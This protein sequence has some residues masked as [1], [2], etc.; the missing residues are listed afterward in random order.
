[1]DL[2]AGSVAGDDGSINNLE[3]DQTS[4]YPSVSERAESPQNGESGNAAE[5]EDAV[6]PRRR[7]SS[8]SNDDVSEKSLNQSHGATAHP[9]PTCEVFTFG[10]NS[11]GE[12]AHGDTLDRFV[13]NSVEFV[14]KLKDVTVVQVAAGNEH[15]ALLCSNG[16]VYTCGYND[17]GQ[18]G[19]G[20]TG[21][22]QS[23]RLVQAFQNKNIVK[24]YSANGCEHLIAVTATGSVYT[25]GY[26]SRGQLGHG[27]TVHSSVP[28]LIQSL[29][30]RKVVKVACSYY[31]SIVA[32]DEDELYSF[33]RNDYGQL[34]HGDT[35]DKAKPVRIDSLRGSR[36]LALSCGQYHTVMSI[37]NVGLLACGKNDYGQLGAAQ[38]GD[39]PQN[40]PFPVSSPLDDYSE[41]F[42]VC[43]I[44]CGYYHTIAL[45]NTGAVYSF[46]RNDYG[47][48]GLFNKENK[49]WPHRIESLVHE[50]I[51]QITCGCYHTL[52][53]TNKGVVYAVGRNNHG[54]LGI[55]SPLDTLKPVRI[56]T[57][58]K[59]RIS[60]IAAGFYHSVCLTT[61][62]ED[63]CGGEA[64]TLSADL[65]TLLNNPA[66][67]DITFIVEGRPIY[68]HRCVLMV[69][70]EPLERMLEG[71]M[72][73][74]RESEVE[75]P[76]EEYETFLAFLEFLYTDT[77]KGLLPEFV[78]TNYA[79]NLLCVADRFLVD[80]LKVLCK[81]AIERS[82]TVE[83]AAYMLRVV[84][85]RKATELRRSCFEFCL[86]HFGKVIGTASFAEL[87]RHLLKEVL[88]E[89]QKRGVY[90]RNS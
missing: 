13:P 11:Y 29:A 52:F 58:S 82:I 51:V 49:R 26:N 8:Y 39:H 31:H 40:T 50:K 4:S 48:L 17:S 59:K 32:T 47:Q 2:T 86:K 66:R 67:S 73:E 70:C 87:P 12:L 23:L 85:E 6:A 54:Q 43:E 42:M 16:D 41:D 37:E 89:A 20:G 83:N 71:P 36:V 77:V 64:S 21:R 69:R 84:D 28:R 74:S 34:G 35:A 56:T 65:G 79:L 75:L 78:D 72:K 25:C 90:L 80:T 81:K 60:H 14:Q 44:A 30:S 18:C 15:T 10:Q 53:L 27:T 61:S 9:P 88:H 55:T 5:E 45:T 22:V 3:L 33:G 1:M 46:G 7:D 38:Y 19:V 63:R 76:G 68:A 62:D 24:V 57:L